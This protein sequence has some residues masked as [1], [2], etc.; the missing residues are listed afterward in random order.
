MKLGYL[1]VASFVCTILGQ[2]CGTGLPLA[3]YPA[4]CALAFSGFIS[5]RYY[6]LKK[7]YIYNFEYF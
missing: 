4:W 5:K 3:W 7:I 6:N 2:L 1:Q